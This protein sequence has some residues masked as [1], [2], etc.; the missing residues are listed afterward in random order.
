MVKFK[1]KQVL[2]REPRKLE[3]QYWQG[4]CQNH[5]LFGALEETLKTSAEYRT[6]S[7]CR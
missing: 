4:R 3:L 7:K 1:F 5:Q 2:C 6:C